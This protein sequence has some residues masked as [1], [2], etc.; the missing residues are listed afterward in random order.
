MRLLSQ[1]GIAC[2]LLLS[3]TV[4][5]AQITV[6]FDQNPISMHPGDTA[7]FTGELTNSGTT[8]L[9]I[10]GDSL[11]LVGSG[12]IL[13]DSPF[14]TNAPLSL[15]PGEVTSSFEFFTATSDALTPL[16][17]YVG[18][19]SVLG[20][21]DSNATDELSG[22][23]PPGFQVNVVPSTVSDVPEPNNVALLSGIALTGTCLLRRL[24]PRRKAS[25]LR[26]EEA[27]QQG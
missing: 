4:S 3:T 6:T 27:K 11:N 21:A 19:F 16:G 10:N 14:L 20:G 15:T 12:L 18:T 7:S 5:R 9:F 13:D 26:P 8:P 25:S 2:I 22:T 24:R 1:L 23:T 17:T